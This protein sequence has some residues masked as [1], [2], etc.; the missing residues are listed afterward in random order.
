MN[1]FPLQVR[2][3]TRGTRHDTENS[4]ARPSRVLTRSKALAANSQDARVARA[5]A[6]TLASKAKATTTTTDNPIGKRKR[7]VLVEVTG[8]ANNNRKKDS[9][10]VKGKA[11][12]EAIE[13]GVGSKS[14][15][16]HK[17]VRESLRTIV[18]P[19]SRRT[20]RTASVVSTTSTQATSEILKHADV[21]GRKTNHS[22]A[23]SLEPCPLTHVTST[24]L[25]VASDDAEAGRVLKK[26]HT[27]SPVAG[28]YVQDDSQADAD[29]V[30][31]QLAAIEEEP[32]AKPQ[33]WEDLD[34]D[35]WDDPMMVSEYVAEVCVYLKQVEVCC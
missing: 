5:T 10:T 18:G 6:P 17:S 7:E 24:R 13:G 15:P 31:A 4:N 33:L 22:A 16:A 20:N 28:S 8:I 14:R 32:E 19:V 11:K 30:A 23:S 12:E 3:A 2:R 1:I 25:P 35:D 29:K 21:G 27:E 34:E 9:G 26:R